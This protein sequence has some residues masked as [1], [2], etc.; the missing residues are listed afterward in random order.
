MD[1][2]D[3][4]CVAW[5]TAPCWYCYKMLQ[6]LSRER[7]WVE[8]QNGT[9][10]WN[11]KHHL[12]YLSVPSESQL[13]QR[14][15]FGWRLASTSN[16]VNWDQLSIR[17]RGPRWTTGSILD[18]TQ[19]TVDSTASPLLIFGFWNHSWDFLWFLWFAILF[20]WLILFTWTMDGQSVPSLST[21]TKL[22]TKH[23]PTV[24]RARFPRVSGWSWWWHTPQIGNA[25]TFHLL[26]IAQEIDAW[27]NRASGRT[28]VL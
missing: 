16:W 17:H 26:E 23:H 13:R 12:S 6:V 10:L 1:L 20:L 18:S 27:G 3:P 25:V 9:N 28:S 21:G 24:A 4:G 7:S 2:Y 14:P 5:Y 15:P 11:Y 22:A 8:V 19:T